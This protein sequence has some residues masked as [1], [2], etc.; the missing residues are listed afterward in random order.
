[1]AKGCAQRP[2]FDYTETFSPVVRM[3]TFRAILAL[4]PK[5]GLKLHQMDV[6]GAYLNGT[7]QETIYMQQPEGC[8]DGTGHI[9]KL[10][11]TLYGLKQAGCKWNN[12]LDGKLKVHEYGQLLSDPCAYI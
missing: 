3:D 12:K 10:V 5:K 8:E 4:I 2:G 9:C 11:K 7:L 1:M 6:K